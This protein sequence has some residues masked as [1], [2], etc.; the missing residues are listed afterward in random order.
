MLLTLSLGDV[1]LA[2]ES[3]AFLLAG[4]PLTPET[5]S[6]CSWQQGGVGQLVF[7]DL[8]NFTQ[9]RNVLD[10]EFDGSFSVFLTLCQCLVCLSVLLLPLPL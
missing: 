1:I 2:P 6:Q 9:D 4:H 3:T 7:S 5:F 10:K 8:S